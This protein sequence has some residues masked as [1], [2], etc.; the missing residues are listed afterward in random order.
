MVEDRQGNDGSGIRSGRLLITMILAA[1]SSEPVV[2][3]D[4]LDATTVIGSVLQP[5]QVPPSITQ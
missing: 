5:R 1:Y 3:L 2:V 4:I